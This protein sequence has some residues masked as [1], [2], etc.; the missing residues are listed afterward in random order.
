MD[1]RE[2]SFLIR[3]A[4]P[5]DHRQLLGLARELDSINLPTEARDLLDTLTRSVRAFRGKMRDRSRAVYLF[6]AE[7]IAT[8]RIA[9]ASMIIG[10]QG[11]PQSAHSYLE[12][13]SDERYSHR[14]GKPVRH[15]YRRLR[16][17]MDGPTELGGLIVTAAMRGHPERVGK[18][19]SLV[20]Y[21]YIAKHR[22]RFESHVVAE[23]LA[24]MTLDHGNIFWDHYGG[25]VTGL[26]FREADQLSSRDKRV[27]RR[28]FPD[29]PLYTFLLPQHVPPSL[30]P[31][32]GN[33]RRPV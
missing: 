5:R 29:S 6:G 31:V 32:C 25:K 2:P 28:L 24:P 10:K 3:E 22:R 11:T 21:L 26:S 8:G 13:D 16:Y 15:P 7:E 19:I 17:S 12:M 20:R 33:T 14:L 1:A 4:R 27:I 18:Q 30:A 9:A 23:M